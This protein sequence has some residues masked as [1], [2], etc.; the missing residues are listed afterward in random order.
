[1]RHPIPFIQID[2]CQL[3]EETSFIRA[4]SPDVSAASNAVRRLA[5]YLSKD[6]L[7]D[8]RRRSHVDTGL[9]AGERKRARRCSTRACVRRVESEGEAKHEARD[10]RM[11]CG[12]ALGAGKSGRSRVCARTYFARNVGVGFPGSYV[13]ALFN[14]AELDK[15][16]S[17]RGGA[18]AKSPKSSSREE[19]AR[20]AGP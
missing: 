6:A 10:A 17:A 8:A 11:A 7:R 5:S 20:V 18:E 13:S 14:G 3:A 1:M 19:T 9:I 15:S 16:K 4:S 12:G 2:T